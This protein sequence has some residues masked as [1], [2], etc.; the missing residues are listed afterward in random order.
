ML[1]HEL[2]DR[3]VRLRL[4]REPENDEASVRRDVWQVLREQAN[5]DDPNRLDTQAAYGAAWVLLAM[6]EL[7]ADRDR[8][9]P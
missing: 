1:I 6:L 3:L 5:L 8:P 4:A 7:E 9:E 2:M